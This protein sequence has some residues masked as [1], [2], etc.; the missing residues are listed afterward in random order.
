LIQQK[1][2]K[3]HALAKDDFVYRPAESWSGR[4]IEPRYAHADP[5]RLPFMRPPV[6]SPGRLGG[7]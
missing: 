2:L 7:W 4:T 1:N 5:R 3:L 6:E